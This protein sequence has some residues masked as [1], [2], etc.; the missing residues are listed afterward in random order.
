M[1]VNGMKIDAEHVIRVFNNADKKFLVGMIMCGKEG[2]KLFQGYAQRNRPWRDHTAHARQRLTGYVEK[3]EGE[4]HIRV[5][6][7]HGVEYGKSLE[8]G[9]NKKYAILYPTVIA[10]AQKVLKSFAEYM[11]TIFK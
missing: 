7:A 1:A 2:A 8:F 4:P 10:N 9:H 3:V 5:C 11:A 6:I